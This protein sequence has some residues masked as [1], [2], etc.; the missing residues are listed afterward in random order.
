MIPRNGTVV[1]SVASAAASIRNQ[2]SE[3][4]VALNK[5]GAEVSAWI[6]EMVEVSLCDRLFLCY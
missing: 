1:E 5:N 2:R 6:R 4:L 3:G